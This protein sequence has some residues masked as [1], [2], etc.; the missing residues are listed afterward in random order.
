MVNAILKQGPQEPSPSVGLQIFI[1][2]KWRF[3]RSSWSTSEGCAGSQA[4][5]AVP[6][7][8]WVPGKPKGMSDG[9]LTQEEFSA[10]LQSSGGAADS[11]LR[12][13]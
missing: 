10:V 9:S 7:V 1:P 5:A 4:G 12:E 8:H 13:N 11:I 2:M 3:S 6:N